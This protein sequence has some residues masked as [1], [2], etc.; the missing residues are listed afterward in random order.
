V[1]G[2]RSPSTIRRMLSAAEREV[3][4]ASAERERLAA[5]LAAGSVDHGDLARLGHA[6]A[7]ADARVAHA[8][9]AWLTVA[10]EAEAS[11]LAT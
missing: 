3:A 9:E 11:G 5:L 1:V 8:E 2:A 7:E 4:T 10:A 6:M